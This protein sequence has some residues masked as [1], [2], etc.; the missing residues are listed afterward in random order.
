MIEGIALGNVMVDC[1]DEQRLRT[2][3]YDKEWVDRYYQK[4]VTDKSRRFFA[5]CHYEKAVGEISLK[6]IDFEQ[7][8]ATM[9]VVFSNDNYKNRGWGTEAERLIVDYAFDE[10]GL[11]IIYADCVLRNKR[12]QHVLEK[13]GFI[14][15]HEDEAMRYYVFKR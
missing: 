3:T 9:S 2:Y 1:G 6:N 15:S 7:G 11:H 14:Y 8:C 4:K 12:S 5:I 13:I 10:L